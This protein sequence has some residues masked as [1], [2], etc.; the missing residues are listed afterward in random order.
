VLTDPI[1]TFL[2]KPLTARMSTVG[3]D[4]YPHTV[5]VW[6]MLDGDDI[7]ITGVRDTLKVKH[8]GANPKG[9]L[10][11][12]GGPG[13][14]GGYLFKGDFSIEED[15]DDAWSRRMCYRYEEPEQAEKDFLAWTELDMI[16][17]RLKIKRVN[18]V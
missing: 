14:G 9:A 10:V 1:R 3:F 16:V 11:V 18:K 4:G 2:Q 7:V 17:I 8:I 6:F 15:P 12:G 5:P 13:E